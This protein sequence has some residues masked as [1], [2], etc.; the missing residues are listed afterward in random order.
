MVNITLSI[1]EE[2]K[3]EME[4]FKIMNW[5][6]VARRAIKSKIEQLKILES[7]TK[8][9]ELTKEDAIRLGKKVNEAISKRYDLSKGC[10]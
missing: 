7:F 9:S 2:L 8:D 5:S 6:E 1:P 10:K 3:S 4:E